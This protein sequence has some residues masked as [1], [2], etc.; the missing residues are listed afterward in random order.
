MIYIFSKIYV[1]CFYYKKIGPLYPLKGMRHLRQECT[2]LIC[3]RCI[4]HAECDR[5]NG[6][7]LLPLLL[8]R[9]RGHVGRVHP[10]ECSVCTLAKERT[11][12]GAADDDVG[13]IVQRRL[14]FRAESAPPPWVYTRCGEDT[15]RDKGRVEDILHAPNVLNLD[16]ALLCC[17]KKQQL[18]CCFYRHAQHARVLQLEDQC[19][20]FTAL[21][22]GVHH[23]VEP[24]IHEYERGARVGARCVSHLCVCLE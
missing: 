11:V 9:R 14:I 20:N 12:V 2:H 1:S 24:S 6:V 7:G 21:G 13:G 5:S 10:L 19:R 15:A 18:N 17:L 4:M 22:G 3:E 16:V 8:L 23:V